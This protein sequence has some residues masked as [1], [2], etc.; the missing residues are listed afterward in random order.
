MFYF[1]LSPMFLSAFS[2][3]WV[4]ISFDILTDC[5]DKW[6]LVRTLAEKLK[7]V[8]PLTIKYTAENFKLFS[9]FN[10]FDIL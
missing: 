7:I 8:V 6:K 3:D 9:V 4:V 10:C 1:S 2:R 5:H